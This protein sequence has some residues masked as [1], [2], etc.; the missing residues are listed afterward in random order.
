MSVS[1]K[2]S[3]SGRNVTFVPVLSGSH[4]PITFSLYADLAPLIA[5]FVDLSL[6]VDLHLKP[7]GEGVHDRGSHAVEASGYLVS[8]AAEFSAGMEDR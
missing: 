6:V 5:L 1:S 4:S 3:L 2:I 8:P 7:L